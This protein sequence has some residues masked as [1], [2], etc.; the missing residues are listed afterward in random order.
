MC[1]FFTQIYILMWKLRT[2]RDELKYVAMNMERATSLLEDSSN[3]IVIAPTTWN[4]M[5]FHL[6]NYLLSNQ[7]YKLSELF[8]NQEL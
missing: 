8:L 6:C 4:L 2:I 7:T 1:T 3:L 5:S